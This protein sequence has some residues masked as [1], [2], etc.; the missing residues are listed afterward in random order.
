[1][2]GEPTLADVARRV[3]VSS[4]TVS[5]VLGHEGG[6]SEATARRVRR[7]VAELRYAPSLLAR[8]VDD[9]S[10]EIPPPVA[11]P[12]I[13]AA[14]RLADDLLVPAAQ[15]VDRTE[16]PQSHLDALADNGLFDLG[17]LEPRQMRRV[18]A[19]IGGGCGATFFVWVQHHGVLRNLATSLNA[20]LRS[21][22]LDRFRRGDALAG[23]AF[24][25][26]RRQ[27]PAAV[28]AT[29]VADGWRLDGHAPWA[30]S[31]GIA[32]H[33]CVAAETEDGSMVWSMM[34][35][36]PSPGVTATAL[37]LAVFSAT[38]TVA[39]DFDGCV[40]ADERVVRVEDV[41]AWRAADRRRAAL[42]QPAVLGV[43]GRALELLAERGDD[44]ARAAERLG[45]ELARIWRQ[46]DFL[47]TSAPDTS[48]ALGVDVERWIRSASAH[49]AEC[50]DIARRAT[51]AFLAASG[52]AGMD[53]D[54]PAQ[55][56]AREATF[57]VIQA[58]TADG[59]AAT[60]NRS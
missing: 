45:D 7:A 58:Q 11:H 46:D 54:H 32:E 26:V 23:I 49:R 14:L 35:G 57:Y 52:G 40:V 51:T 20:P 12:L 37:D 8:S 6:Y 16:V 55:R 25:H 30:T 28:T 2:A 19:A 34:P 29:R 1:M 21:E 50:L 10:I 9:E 27:G 5:R 48:E 56:L 24:A 43:A 44:A 47:V 42:G 60:L 22:L 33:F 39:F 41:V 59:R 38:G 3:G 15:R 18:I 13:D 31:W 4:R 17:A 36:R 53:L